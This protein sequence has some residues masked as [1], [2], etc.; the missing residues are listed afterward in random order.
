VSTEATT[1]PW[2]K[3]TSMSYGPSAVFFAATRSSAASIPRYVNVTSPDLALATKEAP[4]SAQSSST[5][6]LVCCAGVR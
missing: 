3:A 6:Y 2:E 5:L 1:V 4:G